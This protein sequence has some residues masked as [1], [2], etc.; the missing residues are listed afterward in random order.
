MVAGLSGSWI[1][2]IIG[3]F[4]VG[5]VAA[6]NRRRGIDNGFAAQFR[7]FQ[8]KS[9]WPLVVVLDILVP[10][11]LDVALQRWSHHQPHL[12]G[13]GWNGE[14]HVNGLLTT[15]CAIDGVF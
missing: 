7:A 8:L 6:V 14:A 9:V 15:A 11:V 1:I 10:L 3:E 4:H 2:H 12:L 13:V 5:H